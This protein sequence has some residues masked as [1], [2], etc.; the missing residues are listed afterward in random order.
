MNF[1]FLIDNYHRFNDHV[2]QFAGGRYFSCW[3]D[4]IYCA[5]RFGCSPD[6]FFRYEFYKKSDFE[7]DKFITYK[8][9]QNIIRKY[10]DKE[11]NFIFDDKS[12]F[13]KWFKDY[14]K[15]DWIDLR[16]ANRKDFESFLRKHG[17]A[18]LKPVKGGQG[19]DIFILH[20]RDSETFE[21]E[22][23]RDYIA[24]ELLIQDKKMKKLNPSSV[25]TVRVLTF[26]GKIIACALRI[27][28]DNSVV[29]NLHS[30]GVCAHLDLK[31]GV[32]DA[33]CIDNKMQKYLYHPK[34]GIKLV[35]F[36][37]PHWKEIRHIV[38]QASSLVP[39][40]QYVGWD[41][42]VLE[43][44]AAIIEGNRDPGHSVVQMIVQSGLYNKIRKYR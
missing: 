33:L 30:N 37:V 2:K 1:Q 23:Y 32:I 35:G 21:F 6:D 19:R 42:A 28:G 38:L 22:R 27:G 7:R 39:E 36:C 16:T 10:N 17:K 14:I 11:K 5:L 18:I 44:G 40:V 24:E 29:D 31:T 20:T 15:R 13:N 9:S 34:T 8:R 12:E 26:K 3:K 25:N 41:V 43:N 4:E